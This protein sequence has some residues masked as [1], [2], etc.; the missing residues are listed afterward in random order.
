MMIIAMTVIELIALLVVLVTSQ[1]APV[2]DSM[3]LPAVAP[4]ATLSQQPTAIAVPLRLIIPKLAL[5]APIQAVGQDEMGAMLAPTTA[6]AVTWYEQGARPGEVGN[7]VVAGHLDQADG[8]PA[9]FSVID[10]L[11]A[12][13]DVIVQA[14][15]GQR[16][17]FVV[18]D[19]VDYPFDRAPLS[20]I[21]GFT[22]HRQLNL[23]TCDGQWDPHRQR[24]SQRLVVYTQFAY[25]EVTA[26]PDLP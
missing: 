11:A 2:A 6:D 25:T 4:V 24:Y 13:D 18:L 7:A 5:D 8:A 15:A 23:I 9:I 21:F 14:A 22:L 19:V 3:T 16:H 10:H 17:H 1:L 20:E 12:G 26:T